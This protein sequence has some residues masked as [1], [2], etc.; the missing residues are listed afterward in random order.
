MMITKKTLCLTFL[1]VIQ[2]LLLTAT[3]A[4]AEEWAHK[5]KLAFDTTP[6]G[7]E[8]TA[9]V[10]QLPLLIRLHSGNFTFSE[11]KPDGTDLRFLAADGK[12]PLSYHI[13]N[14]DPTNELANVWVSLP[15]LTANANTDALIM[16]WGNPKAP[17]AMSAKATYDATQLLVQH[18]LQ[19]FKD[20]SAN[21]NHAIANGVTTTPSGPVGEAGV[22]NGAGKLVIENSSTLKVAA[23]GE[24]TLSV[25]LKPNGNDDANILQIGEGKTALTWAFTNGVMQVG[26][27]KALAK[28]SATLSP[29]VWQHVVV[30]LQAGKANF[31]V[32]GN[33]AGSEPMVVTETVGVTTIGEAFRGEMDELNVAGSARSA[34]YIK[35]L[36]AS[37]EADSMMMSF[38]AG[39]VEESGDSVMGILLDA[40]TLDG[41]IV[42]GLLAVM[43][44][45]S[46]YVMFVKM[47]ILW[48]NGKANKVFLEA[49]QAHWGV[50][51]TPGS[52]EID[53]LAANKQLKQS[54]IYRLYVIGVKEVKD[55]YD[56]QVDAGK[57]FRLS[58]AG[59][60]SVRAALDAA[61]MRE[62]QKLNS[63]IVLLTISI[64]GG[65]FLGLLGTVVGVMITFAAIA[66]AGDVNVNAIAPGIAAALVATVAGLAVA[67]P[68]LF[69]YNWLASQIKNASNDGAVFLD[70]FIT[71]SAEMHSV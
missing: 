43:A 51:L 57:V 65:P 25:W 38:A 64:A 13:E 9:D 12:T 1:A 4:H 56:Q 34:A 10:A 68:A 26:M 44:V 35:A 59:L 53:Q 70:E 67:I 66:A 37:Q 8:L 6:N 62:T 58:D 24:L 32:N 14:F 28:A 29:G 30:V 7:T 5:K 22:F 46:F 42:I 17:A 49:F 47:Y 2:T 11:A 60:N 31:Y 55:R 41:W 18:F 19:D 45:V 36:Y 50:L 63:G 23:A 71:K 48:A 69:G 3:T 54:S 16:A 40:V 39:A 52:Q 27:D 33:A 15:K 21:A 20:A 61:M